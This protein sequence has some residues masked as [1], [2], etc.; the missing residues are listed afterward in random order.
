MFAV[1]HFELLGSDKGNKNGNA[2]AL[3]QGVSG[4]E[5]SETPDKETIEEKDIKKGNDEFKLP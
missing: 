5:D 1:F 4:E 2:T 3:S